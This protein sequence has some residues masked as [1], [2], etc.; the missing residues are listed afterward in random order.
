MSQS[1]KWHKFPDEKPTEG[2]AVYVRV[3]SSSVYTDGKGRTW[4]EDHEPSLLTSWYT[5]NP[6]PSE[7]GHFLD[8]FAFEDGAY[9]GTLH[10][11]PR[12]T[13]WYPLPDAD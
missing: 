10:K 13:H 5:N 9:P 1:P 11:P 12:V 2:Q 7:R 4:S 8:G 6:Y 3:E